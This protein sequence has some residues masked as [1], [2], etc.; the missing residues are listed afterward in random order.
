[1]AQAACGMDKVHL[2]PTTSTVRYLVPGLQLDLGA[3]GKG[4]ALDAAAEICRGAGVEAGLIHAGTSTIVAWG[5]PHP[6]TGWRVGI[7]RPEAGRAGIRAAD[8]ETGARPGRLWGETELRDQA[9]GVS[10]IWG[11]GPTTAA[12]GPGHVLDPRTGRPV[13]HTL[14]SAVLARSGFEADA[15]S[16]A[17]LVGGTALQSQLAELTPGWRSLVVQCDPADGRPRLLDCGLF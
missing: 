1:M 8:L 7:P 16:T 11:R 14:M 17:L 3:V 13:E 5:R 10:A 15:F 6:G 9:L 12:S 4:A 2:D